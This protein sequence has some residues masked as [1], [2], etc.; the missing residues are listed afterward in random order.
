[1]RNSIKR[2]DKIRYHLQRIYVHPE[3]WS[4]RICRQIL[5]AFPAVPAVESESPPP[6]PPAAAGRGIFLSPFRGNFLKRCPCTPG[7]LGC[8]YYVLNLITNCTLGCSY[9]ILQ[10]YLDTPV[11]NIFT[12]TDNMWPELDTFLN[13]HP[14][15][16]FRIGTGELSDSFIF[17]EITGT[18]RSL[19]A[20]FSQTPNGVLE[21][22]TKTRNVRHLLNVKHGGRTVLAWSLN[23]PAAAGREEAGAASPAERLEE[24]VRAEKKGFPVAFHFDPIIHYPNCRAEYTELVESMLRRIHPD[25]IAWISL[26]SL[27]FMPDLPE[28]ASRTHPD[29]RIF[30]DE[31]I[32][33]QDGKMRYFV[34]LRIALYR[35]IAERIRELAPQIPLYLCMESPEVWHAVLGWAPR[36]D[37]ELRRILTRRFR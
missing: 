1:M 3:S 4:S 8:D 12:N 11:I 31:F 13:D 36:D 25:S 6:E 34:D 27:R 23:P 33:G 35:M 22:K 2:N 24:A 20:Y 30:H 7:Y 28:F 17:D 15:D 21:L 18:T 16:F 9:C 14:A 26:G 37:A 32:R 10:A 19:A 5:S 29:T